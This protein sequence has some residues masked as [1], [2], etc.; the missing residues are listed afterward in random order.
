MK[1]VFSVLL[2]V[3]ALATV[4]VRQDVAIAQGD[5][6]D[7]SAQQVRE[8]LNKGIAYLKQQQKVDGAWDDW[9]GQAGG[10]SA[11]CSLAMLNA[12][13][14]PSDP[15]MQKA[16]TYLRKI[17][18]ERTY[19]TSLQTMVFVRAEPQR[20]LLLI[21]RN[22]KW[23]ESMQILDGPRKGAWAYP[24]GSG[25]NSNSQFA[26]LALYEA[27]RAG[28]QVNNRTWRLAQ[29]Y[30]ENCQNVDG[31]WGYYKPV[32][33]TGSMTCAGITS[34]VITAD[35]IEQPDAQVL[36]NE[37][38]CCRQGDTQIENRVNGAMDWLGANFSV[39]RNPG[40]LGG[41]WLY[42]YLYGL[43]RAG[44][45]TA[46]RFIGKADW[47]RE[48]ANF[49]IDNQDKLSGFWSG[50]GLAEDSRLIGTSFGLLFLSKGRWPVLISK[51]KHPPDDDWN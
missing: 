12:G 49:L 17:K 20:D 37:I 14:D 33:G 9:L 38:R 23:L 43:E 2:P 5:P 27:Q 4:L 15:Q 10:I 51:L 48:G 1:P 42:Y 19:V 45:L 29:T 8:A 6:S 31:S 16:L 32:P 46:R 47:Y 30:W 13:I 21:S 39:S 26:L 36:G 22:V 18:P 24:G 40:P 50:S 7:I 44:R 28:V 35:I 3:F 41:A 34:L 25:D 11:L